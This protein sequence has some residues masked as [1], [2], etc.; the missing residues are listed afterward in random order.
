MA[1]VLEKPPERGLVSEVVERD[2]LPSGHRERN[3]DSE[4][5]LLDLEPSWL[6]S[7]PLSKAARLEV[8]PYHPNCM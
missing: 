1:E 5:G 6:R 2:E 3:C 7:P 4:T 8:D